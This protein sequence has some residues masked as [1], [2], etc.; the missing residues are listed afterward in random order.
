MNAI[1]LPP[2][3]PVDYTFRTT[4][5]RKGQLAPK[6]FVWM[7]MEIIKPT[8]LGSA[9]RGVFFLHVPDALTPEQKQIWA[10]KMRT[11]IREE[12]GE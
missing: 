3:D 12:T 11:K 5:L 10:E 4:L 1:Q 9:R 7:R 8:E 6:G 2:T